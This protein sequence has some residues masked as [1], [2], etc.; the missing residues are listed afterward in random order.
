MILL[1]VTNGTT[2]VGCDRSLSVCILLLLWWRNLTISCRWSW[3]VTSHASAST[4]LLE[5]DGLLLAGLLAE[6]GLLKSVVL[7]YSWWLLG[8]IYHGLLL[9]LLLLLLLVLVDQVLHLLGHR[10]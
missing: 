1:E 5:R 6:H 3:R 7:I 4:L 10:L 8:C 2:L 9:L